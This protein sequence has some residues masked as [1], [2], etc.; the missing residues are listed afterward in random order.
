MSNS[1]TI[2][3]MGRAMGKSTSQV[4]ITGWDMEVDPPVKCEAIT[5]DGVLHIRL[6]NSKEDYFERQRQQSDY[7]KI[8]R[9]EQGDLNEELGRPRHAG[10]HKNSK[11]RGRAGGSR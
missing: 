2:V 11:G 1:R 8:K 10:R 5:K 4:I 3:T 6:A 7:Y 9:R